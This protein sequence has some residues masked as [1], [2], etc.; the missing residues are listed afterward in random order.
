MVQLLVSN[1]QIRTAVIIAA[2]ATGYELKEKVAKQTAGPKNPSPYTADR[3]QLLLQGEELAD[4]LTLAEQGVRDRDRIELRLRTPENADPQQVSGYGHSSSSS[5]AHSSGNFGSSS[6]ERALTSLEQV[7]KA[8]DG[9]DV[10]RT[11]RVFCNRDRCERL[12]GERPLVLEEIL[13]EPP[14]APLP[15]HL[16]P[17]TQSYKTSAVQNREPTSGRAALR[18][19]VR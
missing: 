5:A 19:P 16:G 12:L 17:W 6:L 8:L 18:H 11:N 2:S 13:I 4:E 10:T 1:E 7:A 15:S 3:Q 9:H 14:H